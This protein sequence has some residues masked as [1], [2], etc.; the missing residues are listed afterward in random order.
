MATYK[1]KRSDS[2]P[3]IAQMFNVPLNQL[4][5][6]NKGGI[7]TGQVIKVPT[8]PNLFPNQSTPP[9]YP[10]PNQLVFPGQLPQTTQNSTAGSHGT[11]G[12]V[13]PQQVIS[14]PQSLYPGHGTIAATQNSTAGSHGLFGGATGAIGATATQ[15]TSGGGNTFPGFFGGGKNGG[16]FK[17]LREARQATRRHQQEKGGGGGGGGAVVQPPPPPRILGT[18]DETVTWSIG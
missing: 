17:T 9:N 1:V 13:S 15:A 10:F 18:R 3:K 5:S 8:P 6:Q 7:S 16:F 4:A 12:A 11:F 14:Q 2:L